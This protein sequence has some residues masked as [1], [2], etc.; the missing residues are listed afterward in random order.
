MYEHFMY[1]SLLCIIIFFLL[2]LSM[3]V[4]MLIRSHDC[5]TLACSVDGIAE[6][7]RVARDITVALYKGRHYKLM[8]SL[9]VW[10]RS[11]SRYLL[12]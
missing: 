5:Y 12:L 6:V 1:S 2:A 10:I 4:E 8:V 11:V 9:S 3:Q 7:L